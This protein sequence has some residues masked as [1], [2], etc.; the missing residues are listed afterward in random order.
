MSKNMTTVP[1]S[2]RELLMSRASIQHQLPKKAKKAKL[3]VRSKILKQ[4][5]V[6]MFKYHR[7][8]R[9][10]FYIREGEMGY[11]RDV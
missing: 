10:Q 5:S 1:T 4:S 3:P 11:V 2:I 9:L 6:P 8:R 7:Y